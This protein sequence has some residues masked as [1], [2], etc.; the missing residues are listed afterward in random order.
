MMHLCVVRVNV[1][2][3]VGGNSTWTVLS[4]LSTLACIFRNSV[5]PKSLRVQAEGECLGLDFFLQFKGYQTSLNINEVIHN[6]D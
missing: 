5:S 2:C 4:Q 3:V 6:I 1:D